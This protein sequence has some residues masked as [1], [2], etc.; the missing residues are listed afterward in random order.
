MK[1]SDEDHQM[2]NVD[3]DKH[4]MKNLRRTMTH[5]WTHGALCELYMKKW[6]K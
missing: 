2:T 4:I 5:R 1:N 6:I 3:E